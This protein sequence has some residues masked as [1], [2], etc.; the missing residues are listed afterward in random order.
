MCPAADSEH[1]LCPAALAQVY[2]LC[3]MAAG[4]GVGRVP[5]CLPSTR[6]AV[7]LSVRTAIDY[8]AAQ[9]Q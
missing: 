3:A 5:T 9:Q 2:Q 4:A 7:L 8:A 1:T 6:L